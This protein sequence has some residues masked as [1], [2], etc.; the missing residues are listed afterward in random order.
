MR[1][2]AVVLLASMLLSS[3]VT[4]AAAVEV[5]TIGPMTMS[6]AKSTPY[7]GTAMIMLTAT[8][9]P[10]GSGIAKTFYTVDEG[11]ATEGTEIIVTGD[12]MH[13][14]TFWSVDNAGNV[15]SPIMTAMIT[16][17]ASTSTD[18]VAPMTTADAQSLYVGA[19]TINFTA[20]D[21]G[22]SGVAHTHYRIDGGT[23]ALGTSVTVAA[24]GQHTLEYWSVDAA[25]NV[26][27]PVMTSTFTIV[28]C[29]PSLSIKSSTS[30]PVYKRAFTVSGT[31]APGGGNKVSVYVKKPGS[32]TWSL[33]SVRAS[34]GSGSWSYRY[35]PTK[36]GTYYFKAT[37]A[38]N[39]HVLAAT[40][41]SM[42]L[43]VR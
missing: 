36:R 15:E 2:V 17:G 20:T 42:K 25:G 13:D 33:L 27:S 39:S 16:I 29:K 40:S 14:L 35:T 9:N 7:I 38:G 8:D 37:F 18:M 1:L 6:D 21:E 3:Y 11:P 34:S 24:V 31:L 32:S 10:G 22:G 5:D 4:S 12:G 43:Y 23:E 19:A 28:G 26:E 30:S 41:R